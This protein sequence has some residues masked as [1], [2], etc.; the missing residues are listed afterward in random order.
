MRAR[1]V[2]RKEWE[3]YIMTV[4]ACGSCKLCCCFYCCFDKVEVGTV[5]ICRSKVNLCE[6]SSSGRR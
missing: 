2:R 3:K 6:E 1:K 5:L 4:V